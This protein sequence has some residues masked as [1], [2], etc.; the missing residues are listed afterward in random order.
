MTSEIDHRRLGVELFN[1]TW[2]LIESREDDD[3]MVDQAHASAYHWRRA[4][5]CR[6]ENLARADWLLA[7]VY[8]LVRRAE[9]A[10]HH[11]RRCLERCET[12]GLRDWDLAFAYEALARAHRVA[13]DGEAVERYREL[14]AGVEIADLEDRELLERDLETL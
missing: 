8:A 12:E 5:E 13:G 14:A 6:P 10:L 7:R 2:R 3:L 9:P 11:A 1:G 4:A